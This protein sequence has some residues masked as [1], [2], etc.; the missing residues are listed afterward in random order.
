[1]ENWARQEGL[2][3]PEPTTLLSCPYAEVPAWEGTVSLQGSG[4]G[5][6]LVASEQV[7]FSRKVDG[8]GTP[9]PSDPVIARAPPSAW[10]PGQPCHLGLRAKQSLGGFGKRRAGS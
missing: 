3:I 4:K 6:L 8:Q 7:P 5:P 2:L 1:M 9:L 10:V